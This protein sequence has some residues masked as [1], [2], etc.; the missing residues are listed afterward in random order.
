MLI[1]DYLNLFVQI[2][3][4]IP[5][6]LAG[7][8]LYPKWLVYSIGF[9]DTLG[10]RACLFFSFYMTINRL[11]IFVFPKLNELLFKKKQVFWGNVS[12]LFIWMLAIAYCAFVSFAGCNKGFDVQNL[13]TTI[14]CPTD[15][16]L[17]NLAK[18][19]RSFIVGTLPLIMLAIYLVIFLKLQ[20]M[21]RWHGIK[22]SKPNFPA[23]NSSQNQPQNVKPSKREMSF[24]FQSVIICGVLELE[25]LAYD[26][27]HYFEISGEFKILPQ[28]LQMW[29]TVH[30]NTTL[31]NLTSVKNNSINYL[32]STACP[33]F[34]AGTTAVFYRN[35]KVIGCT[36]MMPK[37]L[38]YWKA[39]IVIPSQYTSI[40]F[41]FVEM[42]QWKYLDQSI[43]ETR[44][45]IGSNSTFRANYT[46][47]IID[48]KAV[49][50]CN[51]QWELMHQ[52]SELGGR[53]SLP[54]QIQY[55]GISDFDGVQFS[56]RDHSYISYSI[57]NQM[58]GEVLSKCMKILRFKY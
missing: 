12:M 27:L 42:P 10:L 43:K 49:S 11:A 21:A 4:V 39:D 44:V 8:E 46:E 33:G 28:I 53:I 1:S 38:K 2:S 23:Q 57:T 58:N 26:N 50:Q 14:T 41:T 20:I 32:Q 48:W 31:I 25:G 34:I 9:I 6:S 45:L 16:I 18:T 51:N 29:M 30:Y 22:L 47:V 55:D 24:F 7:V 40:S 54:F 3:L 36:I 35:Q 19:S 52:E 37:D 13:S 15:T 17:A 5:E 56:P